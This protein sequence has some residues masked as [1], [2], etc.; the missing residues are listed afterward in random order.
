MIFNST[1]LEI[2][3]GIDVGCHN[4]SVAIGLSSGELL[5]EF[6]IAHRPE[7]FHQFF[8]HVEMLRQA[9]GYPVAVAMEGYNGHARPLDTLILARLSSLQHQQSETGSLQGDLPCGGQDAEVFPTG[10]LGGSGLMED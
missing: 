1:P 6:E 8:D 2:R 3:D 7:G 4:H 9:H 10:S 5:D